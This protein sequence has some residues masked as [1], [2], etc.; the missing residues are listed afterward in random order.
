M[1]SQRTLTAAVLT[2]CLF[3]IQKA[4]ALTPDQ[5]A[6]AALQVQVAAMQGQ[7][8]ALQKQLTLVQTNANSSVAAL[9]TNVTNLQKQ[10]STM[11]TSDTAQTSVVSALQR[12]VTL[13]ASNPALALGP[14]VTVDPNPENGVI[15][16]NIVFH[17][18]NVSIRNGMGSTASNN[19]LGNFIIGYDEAYAGEVPPP[20]PPGP[21]VRAGSHN[22][23][24]G[25]YHTWGEGYGNV[26]FGAR[27]QVE[28]GSYNCLLGGIDNVIAMGEQS[29]ILG[30][31]DNDVEG[32]TGSVVLGGSYNGVDG[33][34]DV[35]GGGT[36]NF[37]FGQSIV[38]FGGSGNDADF[39]TYSAQF[40][41]I[42]PVSP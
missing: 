21:Q 25:P 32:G 13:I 14:F 29:V 38:L 42:H 34:N 24:V 12:Q 18:A 19:G 20:F 30:G 41:T 23:I 3:G 35:V 10:S 33:T 37:L 1:F 16:P 2:V 27:N 26:I 4:Q 40:G 15:G 8:T 5:I 17:G 9:Q 6:I 31:S 11:Q 39:V 28:E 36:D 22:F 7:I